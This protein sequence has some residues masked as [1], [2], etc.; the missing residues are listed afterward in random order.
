MNITIPLIIGSAA[1]DSINPCAIAVLVFLIVYLLAMKSRKKMLQ[2][3]LIYVF[4][5]FLTYLLAGLGLFG[6]IQSVHITKF[7]YY[8]AAAFSIILGLINIKDAILKNPKPLLAISEARHA[9][10]QK[11]IQKASLPAAI[12]LGILV[13]MFELPCTG[14]VY[15]AILS[16]L[17]RNDTL[18][19][20]IFYLVIYNLIFVL[21]LV[22]IL[23][24]AYYGLSPEK[25]ENWRQGSK[26]ALRFIIG[27]ALVGI[28]T[29][30]L[31][32]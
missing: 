19:Q 12:V 13:A 29:I 16:L 25:I 7:I 3:G 24:A 27:L 4:F 23:L 11:Y 14:G 17:A 2:I 31:I 5:V 8:L 20:A 26:R 15:F 9:T 32:L 21:P 6:F 28:G 10:I 1:I 22:A 30:M 18:I